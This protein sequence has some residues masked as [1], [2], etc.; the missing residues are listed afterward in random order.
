MKEPVVWEEEAEWLGPGA[1]QYG[2]K[3]AD[4]TKIIFTDAEWAAI[5]TVACREI[6]EYVHELQ[7]IIKEM[8]IDAAEEYAKASDNDPS[9]L[10]QGWGA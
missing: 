2:L 9:W 7:T 8:R 10:K 4:G 5:Q 1:R 3:R 6:R